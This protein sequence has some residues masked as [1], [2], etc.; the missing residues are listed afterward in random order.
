MIKV[1]CNKC[2][3]TGTFEHI[4]YVPDIFLCVK[5]INKY[6][7][8]CECKGLFEGPNYT[9]EIKKGTNFIAY[10]CLPCLYG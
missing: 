1:K 6:F 10:Y 8:C 4:R 9:G 2:N 3:E 5:C 7:I